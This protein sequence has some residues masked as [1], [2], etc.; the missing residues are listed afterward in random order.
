M[1][2]RLKRKDTRENRRRKKKS[3]INKLLNLGDLQNKEHD[4]LHKFKRQPNNQKMYCD[5][6]DYFQKEKN[7]EFDYLLLF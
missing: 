5:S 2:F 1:I 7:N 4:S 6:D 3:R